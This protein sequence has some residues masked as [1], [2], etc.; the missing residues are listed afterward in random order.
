MAVEGFDGNGRSI[1]PPALEA[2]PGDDALGRAHALRDVGLRQT[3]ACTSRDQF[4][5]D[6]A[7]TRDPPLFPAHSRRRG[8]RRIN[9]A[10]HQYAIMA[11]NFLK[12]TAST[13]EQPRMFTRIIDFVRYQ[14]HQIELQIERDSSG[15]ITC[16]FLAPGFDRL[17]AVDGL[18][19]FDTPEQ[20]LAAVREWVWD[21]AEKHYG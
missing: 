20:A 7:A 4:V 12:R 5:R 1:Q 11:I 16:A 17:A 19:P 3:R 14:N 10:A 9:S 8:P 2:R 21:W 13:L 6:R 15:A 18:G